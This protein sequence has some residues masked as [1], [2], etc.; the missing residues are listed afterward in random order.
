MEAKICTE[1]R[2]LYL[3]FIRDFFSSSATSPLTRFHN[4]NT[5]WKRYETEHVMKTHASCEVSQEAWVLPPLVFISSPRGGTTRSSGVWGTRN[6]DVQFHRRYYSLL[7][8]MRYTPFGCELPQEA[9]LVTP[10]YEKH[11]IWTSQLIWLPCSRRGS[12]RSCLNYEPDAFINWTTDDSNVSV[13][14][15]R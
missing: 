7:L 1:A 15:W 6:L 11:A 2:S 3:D 12:T 8:G 4:V 13:W 5:L 9:L 14:V 10:G